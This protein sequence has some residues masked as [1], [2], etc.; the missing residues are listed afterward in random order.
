MTTWSERG[1]MLSSSSWG[2][3]L[4]EGWSQTHLKTLYPFVAPGDFS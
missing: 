4:R 3:T 2:G 1:G